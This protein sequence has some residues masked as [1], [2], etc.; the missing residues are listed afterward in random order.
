MLRAPSPPSSAQVDAKFQLI[1]AAISAFET[2]LK[3][4]GVWDDTVLLTSSDFGRTYA[5]NGA[6]TDHAWGGNYF[7][8][9][10][11]V[12]GSQLFG[13]FP[14]SFIE[15]SEVVISRNGRIIPTTPWE[16]V[17]Y[18]LAEWFGVDRSS[19]A[20]VLPNA[21]NFPPESLFYASYEGG[22]PGLTVSTSVSS[23]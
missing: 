15:T 13:A 2:E 1:N 18:G 20:E 21:A 9:G 14:S 5:P 8:L 17:W 22:R 23:G 4:Q 19:M 6:G 11:A 10:G 3:A 7:A 12:N 16:S